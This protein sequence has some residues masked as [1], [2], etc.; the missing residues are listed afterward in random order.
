M[1]FRLGA[2]VGPSAFSCRPSL[3]SRPLSAFARQPS[4]VSRPGPWSL[5]LRLGLRRW[6]EGCGWCGLGFARP[7]SGLR[8]AFGTPSG[9][10][11]DAR[12]PSACPWRL[13]FLVPRLAVSVFVCEVTAFLL[14]R[15]AIG[16]AAVRTREIMCDKMQWG[17]K[18]GLLRRENN[19][20]NLYNYEQP[21]RFACITILLQGKQQN[22]TFS[23]SHEQ[24]RARVMPW[25][26]RVP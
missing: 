4:L 1:C 24:N 20:N 15:C 26:E 21:T 9:S 14:P 25:R 5:P 12:P 22:T 7:S 19:L 18:S 2:A 8:S 17:W 6:L 10:L 23:I 3:V 11:R 13:G 16:C